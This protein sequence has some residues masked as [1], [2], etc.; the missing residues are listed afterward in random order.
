M[1]ILIGIIIAISILLA[2]AGIYSV[3]K[4]RIEFYIT[5]L[6]Q[7]FTVSDLNLLWSVAQMCELDYPK[8]LF[9]SMPS[10]TKCM[11]QITSQ[12]ATN[13][14]ESDPK[15]QALITK[16]FDYRTK[17]QNQTD[18]KKGIESTMYLDREQKLRIILPGKGV[19]SS[20]IL[21]NG[22]EIIISV[23]RQK[24]MIPLTAEEWV[25][26]FVS[27]YLWR[28]GDARYVFDST[29]TGHGLFIGESSI[30]LKH[31][32]NLI[33]TQKRKA[34]RAKCEIKA[35]LYII[36]SEKIDY[37]AVE[38]Q[39][40][41]KCLIEDISEAGALIRIGGKG[42]SNV[43]IKLQFNIQN[44]LIIMFGVVRTVE[45]NEATNQ[46]LLHFECIHLDQTMKNEVLSYVYNMLPDREKEV[47]EALKLT[48]TDEIEAGDEGLE[49][50]TDGSQNDL[51]SDSN[52]TEQ[53]QQGENQE[54][55][56]NNSAVPNLPPMPDSVTEGGEYPTISD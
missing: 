11:T 53:K 19:F 37:N 18:D 33:R 14:T 21:N 34:V 55:S 36:K 24:D 45:Y 48:D 10:L 43:Q 20:K 52:A 50:V 12:A 30:S 13:G 27:V 8:A 9:W 26:K 4:Q 42:V 40:G 28:K 49:N 17:L 25:G 16:L 1:Y 15:T 29:V 39:N 44:M 38:T 47:Y 56:Q 22:K 6:D 7:K 3:F 31:S 32:S 5:G 2:F 35:N 54:Q 46:S 41:Y 51:T 23:P